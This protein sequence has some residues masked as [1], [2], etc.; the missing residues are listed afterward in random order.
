MKIKAFTLV[1]M[2][3][4]IVILGIL[5]AGTFVSIKH[6]YL[7]V[8]K[9]K[10]MSDLSSDSQTVV[11]QISALLYDRV[12]SSVIGSNNANGSFTSIYAINNNFT[13]LEWIGTASEALRAGQYSGFVD[14]DDS[15]RTSR[16]LATDDFNETGIN[17]IL[18]D[19]FGSGYTVENNTSII[20]AGAFDN[21][22]I[23]DVNSSFGWHGSTHNL[24]YDINGTTSNSISLAT[25]PDEIYE[26]FYLVD[27]AYAIARK[28]DINFTCT[29]V[30][31]RTNANDINDTNNTLY[32]FYNYRPW[33]NETFC[34]GN[35]TILS[36][37]AK[38]FEVGIINDSIYFN[39]TLQRHIRGSDNNVT[40]SKQKVV[41]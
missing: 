2:I 7:R 37:D 16:T 18:S 33:K 40:I 5:S 35:V 34:N 4:S 22:L 29:S 14:L 11:D 3:I 32:L 10:A 27:S 13:I 15:N 19:K 31:T 41:F 21:G 20:F 26:K 28:A 36:Q 25:R 23:G 12:P 39:L 1:E 38:G 6:L 17:Q 9:S 24:I 30:D 8:A